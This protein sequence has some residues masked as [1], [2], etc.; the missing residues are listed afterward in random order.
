MMKTLQQH[1]ADIHNITDHSKQ[2]LC[3]YGQRFRETSFRCVTAE[4]SAGAQK[5][6]KCFRVLSFTKVWYF[7]RKPVYE[8]Y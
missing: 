1:F 2:Q 8:M 5:G 3:H 6:N 7:A 4:K